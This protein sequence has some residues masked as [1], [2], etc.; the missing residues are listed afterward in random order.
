MRRPSFPVELF[1]H[2]AATS[3]TREL[4]WDCATG[5]GETALCLTHFFER[6]LASDASAERI[7]RAAPHERISYRAERAEETT[8]A[9]GSVD[10]IT[11]AQ[12]L[13]WLEPATFYRQARRVLKPGGILAAWSYRRCTISPAVDRA[14]GRFYET[15]DPYWEPEYRLVQQGYRTLPFP[16]E[17]LPSPE[18]ALRAKWTLDELIE[19]LGTWSATRRF[20]AER[21]R[22]PRV[23]LTRELANAWEPPEAER[24]VRWPLTLLVGKVSPRS[25][26]QAG[27]N[28]ARGRAA[29]PHGLPPAPRRSPLA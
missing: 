14:C 13:H 23:G 20:A 8:I 16:F 3:P 10:L 27:A 25:R 29:P 17:K 28:R 19:H 15:V 6:V 18:L 26:A 7:R 1:L 21:G 24:E 11:V 5:L 22:D 2:L 9:P 4:A 12:A